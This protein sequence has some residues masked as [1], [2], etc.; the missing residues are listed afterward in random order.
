MVGVVINIPCLVA[1]SRGVVLKGRAV[2]IRVLILCLAC[3][4]VACWAYA[5]GVYEAPDPYQGPDDLDERRDSQQCVVFGINNTVEVC[6]P[7]GCIASD[8]TFQKPSGT[9]NSS[10]EPIFEDIDYTHNVWKSEF[11]TQFCQMA[12][13]TK[14]CVG[15]SHK[16]CAKGYYYDS[17]AGHSDPCNRNHLVVK[18]TVMTDQCIRTELTVLPPGA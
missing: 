15:R 4:S 2:V 8:G 5:A 6:M 14:Q 9:Y 11:E 1:G 12:E 3:F 18:Q 17:P 16:P 7:H 10:G 13:V